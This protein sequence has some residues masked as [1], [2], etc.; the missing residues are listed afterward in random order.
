MAQDVSHNFYAKMMYPVIDIPLSSPAL[1]WTRI[2]RG[3]L[4]IKELYSSPESRGTDV[5]LATHHCR[6]KAERW[7]WLTLLLFDEEEK[8]C[9]RFEIRFVV[10]GQVTSWRDSR[11]S[12]R[13]R[14]GSRPF[15]T[16]LPKYDA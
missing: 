15:N 14:R 4:P 7:S 8:I 11:K 5:P 12:N 3:K 13:I 16:M 1:K 6:E 10:E 9:W 2:T